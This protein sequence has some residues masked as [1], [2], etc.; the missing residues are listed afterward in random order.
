MSNVF[1]RNGTYPLMFTGGV[2]NNILWSFVIVYVILSFI[3]LFVILSFI[4]IYI[5]WSLIIV[6]IL[7]SDAAESTWEIHGIFLNSFH[8]KVSDL[9]WIKS[10]IGRD[11]VSVQFNPTCLKERKKCSLNIHYIY[12]Y[13]Y[14][15][16]YLIPKRAWNYLPRFHLTDL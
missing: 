2:Y 6:Y 14:I 10:R 5:L 1:I 4:I 8:L 9:V 7:W 3:I 11:E 16:I 13:I 12:I 15:Y